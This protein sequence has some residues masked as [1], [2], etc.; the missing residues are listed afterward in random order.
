MAP[1]RFGHKCGGRQG[2]ALLG[3]Y[4]TAN[5]FFYMLQYIILSISVLMAP[6]DI[7]L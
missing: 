4:H 7:F 2:G 5:H 1:T 6:I 3:S